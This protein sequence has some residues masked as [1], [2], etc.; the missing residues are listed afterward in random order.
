MNLLRL[1]LVWLLASGFALRGAGDFFDRLGDALTVSARQD[2]WRAKLSGTMEWEYYD[3]QRP[4]P[5]LLEAPGG[6]LSSPRLALFLDAQLGSQGYFFAQVRVDR[7]FDPGDRGLR[8]RLDEY[9]LRLTPWAGRALHVQLGRFATVVGNWAPRHGS[10]ANPFVSAPL[11]YEYLTGIWD[12]EAIR[13]SNVLLQWSHI[14]S[15]LPAG[16][17]AHE[18]GL[19]VPI[20]WGPS[21]AT[22]AAVSGV[23]GKFDFSFELKHAPLSS[24]P[25]TWGRTNGHWR[26]PTI[27]GR[28]GFRPNAMW[29]F[30]TSASSGSYLRP[31]AERRLT[32]GRSLEDYR[33]SVLA[34]DLAFA[35]R[36]WQIWSEIFASRFEIPVVGNADTLSYY[37][38]AKYKFT[39]QWFGALRLNQQVFGRIADRGTM[40]RWGREAW[41]TDLGAGYRFTAH[42]QLK[43]EYNLQRGDA[44]PRDYAHLLA[45]QFTVRF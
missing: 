35:W 32:L 8:M 6:S 41:R 43:L 4:A 37:V 2:Q 21:Y 25:E 22:G 26:Q 24:R 14:R 45:A 11:P 27:G 5:A 20:I 12:S 18:K 40:T 19:R 13:T 17:T 28:L 34:G 36:H 31:F 30:G 39:P 42:A 10:W 44:D 23:A 29:T 33:Q 3:F 15:G 7:G 1:V 16:V 38:E 9:A